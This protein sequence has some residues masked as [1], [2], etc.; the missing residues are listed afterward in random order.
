MACDSY[1][2]A[3]MFSELQGGRLWGL[4]ITQKLDFLGWTF[5]IQENNVKAI[6]CNKKEMYKLFY[7]VRFRAF[8]KKWYSLL[9]MAL[10]WHKD[11]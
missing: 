1:G 5:K 4:S 11:L 2:S 6:E 7:L 8:R 9:P 10:S 3:Y